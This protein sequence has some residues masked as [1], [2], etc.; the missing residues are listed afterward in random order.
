MRRGKI[1]KCLWCGKSFYEPPS[2]VKKNPR[3][4]SLSCVM[5]Y[6]IRERRSE[7]WVEV[8]CENCGTTLERWRSHVNGRKHS[9]CSYDCHN[10]YRRRRT[11]LTCVQCGKEFTVKKSEADIRKTCGWECRVARLRGENHP[12]WKGGCEPLFY[13]TPAWRRIRQQVLAVDG[14]RCVVCGAKEMLQVHHKIERKPWIWTAFSE[15]PMNLITLCRKHHG[16]A[17]G[18]SYN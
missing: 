14:G 8:Q 3:F 7:V 18:Q 5:K 12:S 11:T 10:E 2:R 4:C 1:F 16:E 9:F 15:H 13:L 17:H 6:R